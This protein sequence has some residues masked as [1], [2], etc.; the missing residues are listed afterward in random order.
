[1]C[2]G[3]LCAEQAEGVSCCPCAC[4]IE[5][6]QT[7]GVKEPMYLRHASDDVSYISGHGHRQGQQGDTESG[8]VEL[9]E[10]QTATVVP[11]STV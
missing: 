11:S 9:S 1:M 8:S 5:P 4:E 7:L 6:G 3:Q 2:P 10:E